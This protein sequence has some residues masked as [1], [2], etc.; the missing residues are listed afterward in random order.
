MKLKRLLLTALALTLP[1]AG[2]EAVTFNATTYP[3]ESGPN[4]VAAADLNG[5]GWPDLICSN[6]GFRNNQP[7][8]PGGWNNTLTVLTNSGHGGFGFDATLT[9]G[10]GPASPVAADLNG[11]GQLDVACANN[12]DNTLTV[13]TNGGGGHFGLKATLPVGLMPQGVVAVD[14]A[15]LGR[16]DLVCANNGTNALTFYTNDG[17]GAFSLKTSLAVGSRSFAVIAL[18]ANGD[19][20]MDL[21][22]THLYDQALT[23]L[24]N[25]G[26]GGFVVTATYSV[27]V[28][29]VCVA[30]GDLNGDDR[31]DLVSVNHG[32][33]TMTVLTND[34]RGGFALSATIPGQA[35]TT[36]PTSVAV[37]DVN[38]DGHLDLVRASSGD[39][40]GQWT[41]TLTVLTNNGHGFFGYDTTL[42]TGGR[43]PNVMS[44]DLNADGRPDLVCPNYVDATLT[45]L[46]NTTVFPSGLISW[47]RGEG[48]ASDTMGVHPG[49]AQGGVSYPPAQVG[50]GFAFDSNDD[51]VD[52]PHAEAFNLGA[53]GFT[54]QFW[55][56]GTRAQPD[57]FSALLDKSHGWTDSTGWAL[58]CWTN[59]G[60]VSFAIGQGGGGNGN[61]KEVR[62]QTDLLD[63]RF[64]QVAAVWTGTEGQ[65]FVD[66]ALEGR[67][68]CLPPVNNARPL[69]LGYFWGGGVPQRFFRGTLDEVMIFNR[70]LSP[71]EV[72]SLYY[73]QGGPLQLNIQ[74]TSGGVLL[75]WP[76][77]ATSFGLVSRTSLTA[78]AWASVTNTPSLNGDRKEV[79][80]PANT[81]AQ[82]FFRLAQ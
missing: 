63:G 36:Y 25:N 59:D 23:V 32:G 60:H 33:N 34:G 12:T 54:A 53:G 20:R 52:V 79:L 56:R 41:D 57:Y 13:L 62:S 24:T 17:T 66:G 72:A 11:D 6:F 2:A 7:G 39:G 42:H 37:A 77:S 71:A 78:G 67:Q 18:E 22:C 55:M 46:L 65:L 27:G 16:M 64:H 28:S 75:S 38:G 10:T 4:G 40:A 31:P 21:A 82:R 5:D 45:V 1:L 9:V 81:P 74:S 69:L 30:A 48:D 68:A 47:W 15:G 50:L 51:R 76:A 80:L 44:A 26:V 43:V 73:S 14:T 61:F 19:G 58:H 35:D 3:V 29:P 70:A 49:T 8:T